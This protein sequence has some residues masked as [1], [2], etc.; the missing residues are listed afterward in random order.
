[1]AATPRSRFHRDGFLCPRRTSSCRLRLPAIRNMSCCERSD[2]SP[3]GPCQIDRSCRR[4]SG[5]PGV[6]PRS[7]P[8]PRTIRRPSLKVIGRTADRLRPL[9]S[10]RVPRAEGGYG[11]RT[12]RSPGSPFRTCAS[13]PGSSTA[14]HQPVT[15]LRGQGWAVVLL[16]S[17]RRGFGKEGRVRRRR[18]REQEVR[19]W[20]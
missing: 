15:L 5:N 17:L 4:G 7:L 14:W 20:T 19:V 9:L 6:V 13:A 3:A 2:G 12:C 18:R 1:M 11:C 16:G 8:T 10:T